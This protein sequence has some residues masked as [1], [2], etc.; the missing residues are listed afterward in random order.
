[1]EQKKR[2]GLWTFE[3]LVAIGFDKVVKQS[4]VIS[5]FANTVY[6]HEENSLDIYVHEVGTDGVMGVNEDHRRL[7]CTV[8]D[9]RERGSGI[10]FW[11]A[12]PRLI[13]QQKQNE[14]NLTDDFLK[15]LS[16]SE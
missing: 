3:E 2:G 11:D 1:M 15:G 13:S 14:Q 10:H 6:H 8:P 5:G 4:N 12:L 9:V 16:S 7:L